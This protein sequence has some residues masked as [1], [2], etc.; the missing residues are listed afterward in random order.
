MGVSA[1]L[2]IQ[3][4]NVLFVVNKVVDFSYSY[5]R[6]CLEEKGLGKVGLYS[7][8]KDYGNQSWKIPKVEYVPA[9][10]DEGTFYVYVGFGKFERMIQIGINKDYPE[11]FGIFVSQNSDN[12]SCKFL[13]E[14]RDY[15]YNLG[16]STNLM[17]SDS[18]EE[19]EN[20]VF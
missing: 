12:E 6:S 20:R 8:R 2:F 18:T 5:R 17:L 9:G 16:H 7:L 15:F 3:S 1:N 11:M 19:V 10:S 14:L 4:D 13:S